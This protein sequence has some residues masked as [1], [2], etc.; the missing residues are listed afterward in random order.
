[1][2][3]LI[4][5]VLVLGFINGPESSSGILDQARLKQPMDL[6]WLI[7]EVS[8]LR[9]LQAEKNVVLD[10]SIDAPFGTTKEGIE[11]K[12]VFR[13][14]AGKSISEHLR[15]L[16]KSLGREVF[17]LYRVLIATREQVILIR[18]EDM[19]KVLAHYVTQPGDVIILKPVVL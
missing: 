17:G 8:D 11:T 3:A 12:Y 14:R 15:E 10:I 16:E 7:L 9:E 19:G 5:L 6:R 1:M 4:P 18:P 13:Q 2:N